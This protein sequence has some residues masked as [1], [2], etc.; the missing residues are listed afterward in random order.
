VAGKTKVTLVWASPANNGGA[1]I[2]DYVVQFRKVGATRW[3]TADDGVSSRTLAT[4]TSL[5][6]ATRYEFRVAARNEAGRGAFS[7]TARV[8]TRA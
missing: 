4:V 2:T 6:P 5:K 3:R 1:A 8:R 7:S